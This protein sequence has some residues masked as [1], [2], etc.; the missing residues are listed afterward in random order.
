MHKLISIT[1]V[2]LGFCSLLGYALV[3]CSTL[4][5]ETPVAGDPRYAPVSPSALLMPDAVNGAIFQTNRNFGLFGDRIALNVGDILT[6]TLSEQ[7]R[8]SKSADSSYKKDNATAL[9]EASILGS[10]LSMNNLSLKTDVDFSR[11]FSGEAAS[12]Q[13]NSLKGNIS[14]TVSEVLPNG[15]LRV[16]G[17]KWLT[18]S[19]GDEYIRLTGLVRPEDIGTDN[20][21]PSTKVADARIAYGGTGDFDDTNRMGW[22]ARFFNSEWFPF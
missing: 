10:T 4:T 15:I 21:I 12:D 5:R 1:G 6:I 14:V 13:S 8:S 17:E 22:A 7:T 16:Q 20:T 3:G 9:N 18:L 11:D 19:Q 2:K